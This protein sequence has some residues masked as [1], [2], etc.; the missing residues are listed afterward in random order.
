MGD[1]GERLT[2]VLRRI[3]M[4]WRLARRPIRLGV[5]AVG[6][7]TL[8]MA[9]FSFLRTSGEIN[10][11][12]AS[13][14]V[15]VVFGAMTVL[16]Q[17]QSQRRQYTVGLITA[18]Q[19]AETLSQ[20]DVWMA[21]RISAHQPVGADLTG[22]DE[23]RVLPLLDYYEFLAVLAVR[24]MVDVPLLLN[25][26]GGTMTRCFELCRG[27]VADRRTLAGREIYQALELLA[28]EY[29]RRLPMPPPPAP[30]GQ[31]CTEPVT[32]EPAAPEPVTPPGSVPPDPE[33]PLAGSPVVGTRPAGGAV[34]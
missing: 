3:R 34:V 17:R 14:L 8:V 2:A 9:G 12:A 7:A 11:T 33:T 15:A 30:G 25:L 20:A 4:R 19:S 10:E 6:L 24:G 28:T 31:P 18:F 26:R 13:I 22:D 23:Q 5:Q 1:A 16:Q 29:R 27:Y 32:P 21:R